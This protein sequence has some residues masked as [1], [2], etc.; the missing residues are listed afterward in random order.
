QLPRAVA[1]QTLHEK[2]WSWQED[3][4][5]PLPQCLH[6]TSGVEPRSDHGGRNLRDPS[7]RRVRLLGKEEH[8]VLDPRDGVELVCQ[9]GERAA[10]AR[11][12][13]E[14]GQPTAE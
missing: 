11:D 5:D 6:E 4:I 3:R 10:L 12:V 14:I 9:I 13:D 1:R 7:L 8:A 2:E